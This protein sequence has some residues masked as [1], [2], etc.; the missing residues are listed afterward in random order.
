MMATQNVGYCAVEWMG[1]SLQDLPNIATVMND[2]S[3][4]PSF[5][6]RIQQGFLNQMFLGRLMAHED[7]FGA[8]PSFQDDA[9][10][11]LLDRTRLVYD[12]NSQGGIM[13][14]ALMA[15][16][17]DVHR[18]N[19]GVPGINYSTLLN[20][21]VDWEGL[22]AEPFYP[23]YND[24]LEQQILFAM[25]QMLWD[26]AEGNGYARHL[27]DDPLPGTPP[28]EVMLQIAFADH[29]VTNVAAE[30]LART[31][32]IAMKTPMLDAVEGDQPV[33]WSVDPTFGLQTLDF[34]GADSV[35]AAGSVALY[36]YS[37]GIGNTTPP[38]ANVPSASGADPHSHIRQD[39]EAT[40]QK[41]HWLLTGELLDVCGGI[42]VTSPD[43]RM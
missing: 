8:H 1:M 25:M 29:Q 32:G 12:G 13:G 36:W 2:L 20:R 43:S 31:A 28:H 15:L 37:L 33:H 3:N 9:G 22:Y 5:A 11:T 6:D 10:T 18:G 39:V 7:G 40:R 21:S 26:R 23:N 16:S 27:T 14:A 38:T 4:F 35:P 42:C 17:P 30:V 34:A 19:L 24:K 41:V